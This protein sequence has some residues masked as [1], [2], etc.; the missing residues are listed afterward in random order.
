MGGDEAGATMHAPHCQARHPSAK[1]IKFVCLYV[2]RAC[3]CTCYSLVGVHIDKDTQALLMMQHACTPCMQPVACGAEPR[4][5]PPPPGGPA[6]LVVVHPPRARH[7]LCVPRA[8]AAH[9]RSA[10][11]LQRDGRQRRVRRAVLDDHGGRACR[12]AERVGCKGQP[13]TQPWQI[14]VCFILTR[15][16]GYY[17]VQAVRE[18]A[19]CKRAPASAAAVQVSGPGCLQALRADLACLTVQVRVHVRVALVEVA[20]DQ[21]LVLLRVAAAND[22]VVLAAD[23]PVEALKPEG[24]AHRGQAQ[25]RSAHLPGWVGGWG[26]RCRSAHTQW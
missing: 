11:L 7:D 12:A 21:Q 25:R 15:G 26:Q 4:L 22:E 1:F 19:P 23:E 14:R 2:P 9:A 18:A 6:H 3:K 16:G 10:R 8:A 24:L 13:Q 17:C 5:A 20:L